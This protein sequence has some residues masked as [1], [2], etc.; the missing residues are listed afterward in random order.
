MDVV[1]ELLDR[2]GELPKPVAMLLDVALLRSHGSACGIA[3]V[4]KRG[5]SVLFYPERM[6]LAVW[7]RLAAERRGTLLLTLEMKPYVTL[8]VK[9]GEDI[10]EAA[11]DLLAAFIK[12]RDEVNAPASAASEK[13]S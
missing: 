8:R 9:T 6:D 4:V 7:S 12:L 10:F 1:D 3:K 11:T 5:N 13:G 2:Y